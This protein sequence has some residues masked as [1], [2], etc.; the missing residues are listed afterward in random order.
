MS[1]PRWETDGLR[2][3][4]DYLNGEIDEADFARL[5]SLLLGDAHARSGFRRYA[6]TDAALREMVEAEPEGDALSLK[7]ACAASRKV[8]RGRFWRAAQWAAMF[9]MGGALIYLLAERG[10]GAGGGGRPVA[11]APAEE[12]E[13]PRLVHDEDFSGSALAVLT[14]AVGVKWGGERAYAEG[15]ALRPDTLQIEKGLLQI[16]FFSGASVVVEGP[17]E[18]E[19][20]DPMRVRCPL[21]R[22]RA[23]VPHFARGF[24]IESSELKVVDLGTEFGFASDGE[25][26]QELHVFDGE[27]TLE[28]GAAGVEPRHLLTGSGVRL[29][30]ESLDFITAEEEA[31]ADAEQIASLASAAEARQREQW[32]RYAEELKANGDVLLFY[33]FDNQ[34]AW[35]RRLANDKKMIADPLYGAIVGC[36]WA[37]GRWRGKAALEFKRRTD[38]VRITVPGE[39]D[40]LTLMAWVRIDGFDRPLNSLMLSDG[41]HPGG[42]HWQVRQSGEL[43]LG[44]KGDGESSGHYQSAPVLGQ[45]QLGQWLHLAASYGGPGGEVVHFVN[46]EA[47]A[48]EPVR[49]HSTIS[50]P[51]GEL[52]NWSAT[53]WSQQSAADIR[54]LNGRMDEFLVFSTALDEEGVRAV[55]EKGRPR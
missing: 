6:R 39:H 14:H 13:A 3:T 51:R 45:A 2:W 54:N 32:M 33:S 19:L 18:F 36:R 55:F 21:G 29:A 48:R 31:F 28:G 35:S 46:G 23:N 12:I 15:S 9:A 16:E 42:L 4:Q 20:I 49:D 8:E 24:T 53:D 40:Q 1:T 44:T 47:V 11:A 5:E 7:A 17:A 41:W 38:R 52:G 30:G 37:E 43:I 25:G 10:G 34:V 22:V 50:V 26:K 27:V